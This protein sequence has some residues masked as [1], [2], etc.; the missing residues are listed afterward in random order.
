MTRGVPSCSPTKAICLEE[1]QQALHRVGHATAASRAPSPESTSRESGTPRVTARSCSPPGDQR[2][3]RMGVGE[4]SRVRAGALPPG[5]RVR[6]AGPPETEGSGRMCRMVRPSGCRSPRTP[7]PA[8]WTRTSSPPPGRSSTR[9]WAPSPVRREVNQ[10]GGPPGAGKGPRAPS[11]SGTNPSGRVADQSASA[12]L[13]GVTTRS[14][15]GDRTQSS[16][17][18]CRGGSSGRRREKPATTTRRRTAAAARGA[19]I[20]LQEGPR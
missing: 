10:R 5:S 16:P 7:E 6:T 17:P 9:T 4:R 8:A 18:P 19:A 13:P 2:A 14:P 15:P 1:V 11:S 12:R 3:S 20:R